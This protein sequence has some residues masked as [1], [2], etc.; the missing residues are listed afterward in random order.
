MLTYDFP[1]LLNPIHHPLRQALKGEGRFVGGCVRNSLL[2]RPVDD[3]D[4]ATPLM[5]QEVMALLKNE[6]WKVIPTGLAHGTVTAIADNISYEITTLRIDEKTD[7]R[8]AD[9]AFTRSY[10]EDARR[11]DFTMN[12]LYLDFEGQLYDYFGGI[13]DLKAGVVRF[14]DDPVLRIHEDYLRILRF[15]RIFAYYGKQ[16]DPQSATAC[17]LLKENLASLSK[18]RITKEFLKLLKAEH[19]AH[20][21]S[22][23]QDH[24]FFPFILND[25]AT[26]QH[27][28]KL[29]HLQD[30]LMEQF[31]PLFRLCVLTT[32]P[33]PYFSLSNAQKRMIYQWTSPLDSDLFSFLHRVYNIGPQMAWYQKALWCILRNNPKEELEQLKNYHHFSFPEFPVKGGDLRDLGIEGILIQKNLEKLKMAWIQN[34]IQNDLL[35]EKED[36]LQYL[37]KQK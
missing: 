9:V 7:G 4:I 19:P 22:F 26:S 11:R 30:E 17:C 14:I 2:N 29:V 6:G 23:M 27:W 8:H 21:L 20:A 13:A 32:S 35:W 31:D 3:F 18:E 16:L 36:C 15:F 37:K 34:W 10:P 12:A 5:P 24:N 1:S 28:E 33:L 25:K